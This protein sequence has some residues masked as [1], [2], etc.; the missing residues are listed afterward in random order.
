MKKIDELSFWMGMGTM[1]LIWVIVM[2]IW[3]KLV[4]CG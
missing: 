1:G 2:A 3:M 4:T